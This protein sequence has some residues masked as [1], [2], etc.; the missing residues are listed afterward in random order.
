MKAKQD[1]VVMTVEEK[2]MVKHARNK[3]SRVKIS[4]SAGKWTL[5]I[6]IHGSTVESVLDKMLYFIYQN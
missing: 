4:Q 3:T 6:Q 1:V 5:C 2:L